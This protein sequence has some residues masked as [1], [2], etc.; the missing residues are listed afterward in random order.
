MGDL[1]FA[2]QVM[3]VGFTLVLFTLFVLYLI[4][5]VFGRLFAPRLPSFEDAA[6]LF[7]EEPVTTDGLTTKKT[8]IIS[9]AV[10]AYLCDPTAGGFVIKKIEPVH[11]S[12][13]NRWA[14]EGRKELINMNQEIAKLR[15]EKSGKKI[16]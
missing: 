5:I 3:V 10:Y 7:E 8:A 2:L 15:R 11:S 13:T 4:I 12:F 16:F 1:E 14:S 9:A 6:L